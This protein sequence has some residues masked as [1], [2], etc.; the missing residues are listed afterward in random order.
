MRNTI[1]ILFS[2]LRALLDRCNY[3]LKI[4]LLFIFSHVPLIIYIPVA[5][6]VEVAH[7]DAQNPEKPRGDIWLSLIVAPI[8]ETL[9]F[10]FLVMNVLMRLIPDKFPCKLY[11]VFCV[12]AGLFGIVHFYSISYIVFA[13]LVGLVLSYTY[14]Y[15]SANK[16]I[17]FWSVVLVH[18][19]RNGVTLL[20]EHYLKVN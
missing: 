20:L 9:I 17:A 3:V 18:A 15:F 12:S 7:L 5:A 6:L 19:M 16:N 1:T 2:K 10:Q 11:V 4:L 13:F 14:Y 8:V